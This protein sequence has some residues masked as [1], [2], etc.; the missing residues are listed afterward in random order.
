M[1]TLPYQLVAQR[2]DGVLLQAKEEILQG[3]AASPNCM[4]IWKGADPDW[5]F[6]HRKIP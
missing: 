3:P 6:L 4:Q 5:I 2:H 1:L